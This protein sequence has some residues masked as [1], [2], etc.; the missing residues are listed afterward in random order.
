L[1]LAS[2]AST[3]VLDSNFNLWAS[4]E[5][6][7]ITKILLYTAEQGTPLPTVPPEKVV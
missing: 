7:I 1:V 6:R 3:G 4:L 5:E 2:L